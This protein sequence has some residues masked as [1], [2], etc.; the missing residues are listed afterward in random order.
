MKVVIGADPFASSLK[1]S[2]VAFLEEKEGIEVIDADNGEEIPYYESAK[3]ACE[4]LQRGEAEKGILLCGT[5]A[6]MSIV[7]NKFSGVYAVCTESV[8]AAKMCKAI[9]NAN[10]LTM[11][12]M[13]VG[14]FMARQMVEAWLD[15]AFTEGLDEFKDFLEQAVGNVSAIDKAARSDTVATAQ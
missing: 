12:A 15:T 13:I 3:N 6:G 9:N 4:I 8:F 7:A 14:E 5:G 11:G 10:V 1:S 2:L